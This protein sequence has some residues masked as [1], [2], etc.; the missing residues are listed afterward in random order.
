MALLLLRSGW[1]MFMK[2]L[3][4]G[5][6]TAK[7]VHTVIEWPQI[8]GLTK[9][10]PRASSLFF[11][12]S[13][14]GTMSGIFK[15]C[16]KIETLFSSYSLNIGE[17]ESELRMSAF[18]SICVENKHCQVLHDKKL[19]WAERKFYRLRNSTHV[20]CWMGTDLLR[21]FSPHYSDMLFRCFLTKIWWILCRLK[22]WGLHWP[23]RVLFQA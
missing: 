15:F 17:Q 2:R 20:N 18:D 12:S 22:N 6:K 1:K 23:L 11:F 19:S 14:S 10:H 4:G 8:L 21:K 13:I 5:Q 3:V 7:Y 16:P 9:F